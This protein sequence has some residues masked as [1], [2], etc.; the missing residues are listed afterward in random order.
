MTVAVVESMTDAERFR[1]AMNCPNCG[2]ST[3]ADPDSTSVIGW[4]TCPQ[5]SETWSARLRDG[6]PAAVLYQGELLART[7]SQGREAIR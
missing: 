3:A 2:Q 4:Y 7:G 5:C 6:R 1:S